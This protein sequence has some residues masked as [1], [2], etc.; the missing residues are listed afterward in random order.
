[1]SLSTFFYLM[2][3]VAAYRFGVFNTRRPGVAWNCC[4]DT[5]RWLWKWLHS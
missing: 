4:R 2:C 3:I 1:M 5:S